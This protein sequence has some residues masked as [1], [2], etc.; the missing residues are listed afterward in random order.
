MGSFD[1]CALG[2]VIVDFAKGEN[3]L[4]SANAGG[5][6]AN[7]LAAASKLG[8]STA[9]LGKVGGDMFST[10]LKEMLTSININTDGLVEDSR[11]NTTLAFVSNGKDGERSFSFYR[12]G[13]AD[14]LFE[15][16][17][18]RLDIIESSQILHFGSLSLTDSPC[19]HATFSALRHAKKHGL[20]IS[21]DPNI[22][23]A[24]WTGLDVAR[25]R[26]LKVLKLC[27]IVKMSEE[28]L[29]FL[30]RDDNLERAAKKMAINNDIRLLVIT[31]G[32][33]GAYFVC[34]GADGYC[35]GF[36]ANA[37][38]TTGAGDSFL[39]ALLYR[40]VKNSFILPKDVTSARDMCLF[41]CAAAS[42]SVERVGG[43]PSMPD[44]EQVLERL[45]RGN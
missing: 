20:L 10:Y 12:S 7:V 42:V 44:M 15:P 1:I 23:P 43:I 16:Q 30:S 6:P 45:K 5:A 29:F 28:E 4:F 13:C 32:P 37:I 22:R 14:V 35:D 25:R 38:D 31:R 39:G 19:R 33:L 11:Y 24:L 18:V 3:N 2:E 9:F 26:T 21:F 8:C 40:I 17:E 34:G 27:D 36:K 41:A